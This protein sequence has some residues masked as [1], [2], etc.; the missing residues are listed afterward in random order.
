MAKRIIVRMQRDADMAKTILAFADRFGYQSLVSNNAVPPVLIANPETQEA[1]TARQLLEY[2]LE[3]T[4][5][6][7]YGLSLATAEATVKTNTDA[8]RNQHRNNTTVAVDG[9]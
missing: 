2:V 8:N 7:E 9:Q 3:I 4:W 1:F 6:Y 5:Q